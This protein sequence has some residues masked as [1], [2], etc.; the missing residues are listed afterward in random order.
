MT[1]SDEE[2]GCWRSH[3][4]YILMM[5]MMIVTVALMLMWDADAN[6]CVCPKMDYVT[7]KLHLKLYRIFGYQTHIHATLWQ[8]PTGWVRWLSLKVMTQFNGFSTWNT[9]HCHSVAPDNPH[10][11]APWWSKIPCSRSSK[12]RGFPLLALKVIGWWRNM[13]MVS[14]RKWSIL[15]SL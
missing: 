13:A 11:Q 4:D 5:L 7:I 1:R 15:L 12:G 10:P 8:W 9:P 6:V 3:S 14:I 2:W